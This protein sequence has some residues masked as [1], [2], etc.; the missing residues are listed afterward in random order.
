MGWLDGRVALVTGGAQASA[1]RWSSPGITLEL[2]YSWR[3][4]R[5]PGES[6]GPSSA[7]MPEALFAVQ[8]GARATYGEKALQAGTGDERCRAAG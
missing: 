5:A 4:E 6:P 3:L 7:P 2:T 8:V 1:A